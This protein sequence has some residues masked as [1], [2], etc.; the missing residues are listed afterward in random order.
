M[1][2]RA[3]GLVFT[4][5]LLLG[6]LPAAAAA[7]K[8]LK[9]LRVTP[10]GDDIPPGRQI[11]LEFNRPV[12]PVG[13]MD[14]SADE[15]GI[16]VTPPLGCE[17]RWLNTS[18][19]ACQLGEKAAMNP[20]TKYE[21]RIE[22]R[23]KAEDGGALAM[24]ATYSFLT[25]R[26]SVSETYFRTWRSPGTPVIRAVFNQPV[27]HS[28]V[29]KTLFITTSS[30]ERIAVHA[31]ADTDMQRL[32]DYILGPGA[33][34]WIKLEAGS[35]ASDDQATK[36]NG[37]EARR[38]WLIEPVAELPRDSNATLSLDAGLVSALGPETN[39][40]RNE[41]VTFDTYPDFSFAGIRCTSNDDRELFITK[42]DPTQLCNPL[43]PVAIAFTSPVLRSQVKDHAAFTPDLANGRKDFNPWGE[44]NRDWSGLGV[45]HKKGN[46]YYVGLPV[47]LKAAKTY[48]LTFP[49]P[50]SAWDKFLNFF[51][52]KDVTALEDEFGRT[53]SAPVSF[54]FSTNHRNPNFEMPYA[55]AVLESGIDSEVPLYVNNLTSYTFNYQSVTATGSERGQS[56]RQDVAK[57]DNIQYAVPLGVRAMLDGKS[58]ALFGS[59]GTTPDAP[60]KW[61]GARRLFAQVTPW[62]AHLKF[63][64]FS[65]LLWVTDMKTGKPVEGV[66]VQIYPSAFTTL[67]DPA[68]PVAEATTNADGL[69]TLPGAATLDPQQALLNTWQDDDRRLFVRMEKGGDMALLPLSDR[70]SLS[71][72]SFSDNYSVGSYN[73]DKYGHLKSWGFTAQGVYRA[74]DTIQYKIFLRDQNDR[75]LVPPPRDAH[76]TLDIVDPMGNRTAVPDIQ[77]SEFGAYSGEF[78]LAESAP[79]GWYEFRLRA[80]FRPDSERK[81][82]EDADGEQTG[83]DV[84]GVVT[85]APLSVLVSDFTPAPFRVTTELAGTVFRPGDSMGIETRALLHS[86]GP[87][88]DASARVT[89]TLTPRDFT[90]ENPEAKDFTFASSSDYQGPVELMQKTQMLDDKGEWTEKFTLAPQPVYYGRL[91]VE[92]AVQDDRGKSVASSA[93][94]DFIGAD[95]LVGLKSAK[96]F[97]EARK[98]AELQTIVVDD[99]GAPVAGD[100]VVVSVEYE[101][102]S[103]AKVKGSGN[104]YLSDMTREWKEVASC[105]LTSATAAQPCRFTPAA[106]GSYRATASVTDTKGRTHTSQLSLWVSGEDYVQWNDQ[107]NLALSIVPE[108][109]SYKVGDTA[110]FL[111]KNPYPGATALITVER[112]GVIESFTRKLAD[113]APVI[114]VPVKPDY[115]P[116]FYLSVVVVSPRVDQPPP[117]LGQVDMGKPAF[118]MGY[119]SVP[120]KD[121][122]KQIDVKVRTEQDVYRP[123]DTIRISFDATPRNSAGR[124]PVELAVA[125]LDESVFDL[126][127]AGKLAFDPYEGFYQL[128]QLDMRNYSLLYRLVGKQKFEKKGANAGGDGGSDVDMRTLFKYVSYWNPAL[129]TDENGHASVEFKTPDNLTGWRI[130]AVAVTPSDRAGLGEGNFKVNRPTE[131]RPVMPN[132]VHE[133]DEFTAGFSVMNRTDAPRT[134]EVVLSASGDL[135]GGDQRKTETLTLAPYKRQTVY[136]PLKANFLP[137]TREI[138]TGKIEFT[139]KAGDDNDSDGTVYSLPVLKRRALDVAANYGTTTEA[140]VEERIAVPKDIYPDT[141]DVSVVLS[142]SV[143]GNVTGAFRYMRDYPYLCWEQILSKA[144][145]AAHYQR[146]K[147]WMPASFSWSG[148]E[149]LPAQMLDD[150]ANFQAPNGGMA[151]FIASDDRADPYLSAYTALAFTWLKADGYKIPAAVEEK[152]HAYLLNFLRHDA[153][154]DFYQP[155]MT[156]TV[157]AVALAALAREHKA[158]AEDVLRYRPHM[159]GMS[160]FGKAHYLEAALGVE[161]GEKAAQETLDAIF[162]TGSESG[163]KFIF[164]ETLDDGYERL[165]ASSLRDNCAVLSGMLAYGKAG[166][167]G[168]LVGD[169]PF[170][171]V[172]TITQGRGSRDHWENTQENMFCMNAISEYA[173]AYETEEPGMKVSATLAGKTFGTA[174]FGAF[175][176][177]AATLSRPL[178]AD[179]AGRTQTLKLER[180]GEGRLYYATRLRTAPRDAE[181]KSVN[182]GMEINREYSVLRKGAWTLLKADEKVR[183]GD[184]VRVDL[185]LSLPSSRNYVVVNDPLPGGLETVNRDLATASAV[186]DAAAPYDQAGGSLWFRYDDWTEFNAAFWSFYHRELRHDSARFY[187]DFLP[188]GNYHLSYMT[189]AIA[190]GVFSA[191]PARAEEMYDPDIYAR[192]KAGVMTVRTAQ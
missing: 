7:P 129:A 143:I 21:L 157:R 23:I 71:T 102:I 139:A 160:L 42:K 109:K 182:A 60:G 65:S 29:E 189:Q 161:G 105:K 70:F 15:L 104:A 137:L 84:K 63:G 117:E 45:P 37:E 138:Q 123:G 1:P 176:D 10:S 11:V 140:S 107:D 110:K 24:S 12:V 158:T 186:D 100:K 40:A 192:T 41:V 96:W 145:M 48:T 163:G 149:T 119:V 89:V 130:L 185:Y 78:P 28:S 33:K 127:S 55:D 22:P 106:A 43:R 173:R 51:R 164:S 184:T 111:V 86:G 183:R 90:S 38:V 79:V 57:V 154:P 146:L 13:R 39:V 155:G 49:G 135:E 141:G 169:K 62:Q 2:A 76:Y 32:P 52:K 114:E 9:I 152:L 14:R 91:D 82:A 172:R 122:F 3:W 168:G 133:G 77:F 167:A 80:D 115:L 113:S 112:Y 35:R 136:L 97:Y 88:G 126:I 121:P 118:R 181:A 25:Q 99:S 87:Y 132:Q 159:K 174:G 46:F 8:D 17:W 188:A 31:S 18:S 191:P 66:R 148:S 64:H 120:V 58:G 50:V 16:T 178:T 142:P 153:A 116:G 73:R 108:K 124:Q 101:E 56:Y 94:A 69:A 4:S 54:T 95:R 165:L 44:E 67:A 36:V 75:T 175:T 103:T 171:L 74:G 34:E 47:G 83:E 61:D 144:V 98:P 162:A 177:P 128:D 147:P 81:N 26:P 59:L 20:A 187:A 6:T 92:S 166:D 93:H 179:D 151:Y 53:L 5:L 27:A 30:G 190:D 72:W 150:A 131:I 85:L 170:K 156:A 19:L 68:T 125:V 180:E 134:L